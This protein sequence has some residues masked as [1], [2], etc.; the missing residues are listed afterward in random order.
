MDLKLPYTP[1]HRVD[2]WGGTGG[3]KSLSGKV[4][5]STFHLSWGR[6]EAALPSELLG[7]HWLLGRFLRD[8][9]S[10]KMGLKGRCF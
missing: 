9:R 5:K 10:R 3:S 1:P 8:L 2:I 7:E 6:H 4:T